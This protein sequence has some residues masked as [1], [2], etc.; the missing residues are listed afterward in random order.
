L[1]ENNP[2]L[3]APFSLPFGLDQFLKYILCVSLPSKKCKGACS[4]S[5]GRGNPSLI[6]NLSICRNKTGM[7]CKS[8]T[9][10]VLLEQ[11]KKGCLHK[12]NLKYGNETL[13]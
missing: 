4:F 3:L 10:E 8:K 5:H 9:K 7:I 11:T 6:S 12:F 13:N 1:F 2:I